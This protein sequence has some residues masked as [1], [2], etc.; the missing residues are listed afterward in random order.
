MTEPV[1][2][3][4]QW[5]P[6]NGSEGAALIES[7]CTYCERDKVMNGEASQEDADRDPSL[8]CRILSDSFLGPVKEWRETDEGVF[9][10]A[11]VMTGERLPERCPHTMELEL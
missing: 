1:L 7:Y 9:C 11:F 2:P 6:S 5:E 10:V 3:G 8:Y 4:E